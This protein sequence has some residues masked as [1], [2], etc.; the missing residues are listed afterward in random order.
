MV[1]ESTV[2][3]EI[4]QLVEL[5]QPRCANTYG[6]GPCTAA[7]AA[8]LECF[9]TRNTCQDVDNYRHTPDGH[10]TPTETLADGDEIDTSGVTRNADWLVAIDCTFDATPSGTLLEIGS[11]GNGA[12]VGITGTDLVFRAG[13]GATPADVNQARATVAHSTVAGRSGTIYFVIDDSAGTVAG[14]FWDPVNRLVE[15]LASDTAPSGFNSNWC[16]AGDGAIGTT[17]G[18]TIVGEDFGDFN[19]RIT[20]ARIYD[21]TTA[22]DMTA[23]F[24]I[25][26]FF[27]RGAQAEQKV[28]GADYIIPCLKSVSTTPTK[29]N[30][31]ASDSN[32]TGLG[33]RAVCNLAFTD[34]PH[35]D[36]VVDPY[37]ATRPYDPL[38]RAS[39]WS[40][41]MVR[42]KYRSNM[43]VRVYEGYNGQALADMTRR[44]FVLTKSGGPNEKGSVRIQC[45]D[46]LAKIEERKAQ[47]P[48]AS[49]G[50]LYEDITAGATSFEVVGAV[51]S[52]Y[53]A[54][55][56]VRIGDEL[57]TYSGVATSSNG[58]EFTVTARGS[59][60][61]TTDAHDAEEVVQ[62]C[63]RFTSQTIDD[64]ANELLVT[65]G[66][67]EQTYISP[68]LKAETDQYLT[69]YILST[70]ISQPTAVSKLLSELQVQCRFFLWWDERNA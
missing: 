57:I 34:P 7:L 26:L 67:V 51:V 8:G 1:D 46:V 65:W 14:Y 5:L 42:N 30:L 59:D 19:G 50:L 36:R 55:G 56:T 31:S 58:I 61:T 44:S 20:S 39:F 33:N 3:R 35:T 63:L 4:A 54:S 53:P 10:L 45:K 32:A 62:E 47:A 13:D 66:G 18:G 52:N 22:P 9:N 28:E 41:W 38:T 25:P 64:I 68:S 15:A 60:D 69:A 49:S 17:N 40:K 43:L 24:T 21:A 11:A 29:V 70:V 12:Y 27:S 48:E 16:S 2:G 23:P 37:Q 6:S